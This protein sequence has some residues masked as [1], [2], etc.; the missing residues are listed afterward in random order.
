M[1]HTPPISPNFINAERD[2]HA[3]PSVDV[4]SNALVRRKGGGGHGGGH[5]SG[6]HSGGGGRGSSSGHGSSG[7]HGSSSSGSSRP[8]KPKIPS[9]FSRSP[10]ALPF[11]AGAAIGAAGTRAIAYSNGGGKQFTLG[12]SSAFPGRAAGGGTRL[13]IFGTRRYGSGYPYGGT[14][15]G[16]RGRPFPFLFFPIVISSDANYYNSQEIISLNNTLRPGGP[17]SQAIIYTDN[18][19]NLTGAAAANT[20]TYRI[21]GDASS[22]SVAYTALIVSCSLP[23]TTTTTGQQSLF[24]PSSNASIPPQPSQVVQYYRA[25]SFALTLDTYANPA[26]AIVNSTAPDAALP[27]NLNLTLL[28]CINNT[29]GASLPLLVA[30]Q[31]K[32]SHNEVAG[33][34]IGSVFLVITVLALWLVCSRRRARKAREVGKENREAAIGADVHRMREA[35]KNAAERGAYVRVEHEDSDDG[36]GE[37]DGAAPPPHMPE[38]HLFI[39]EPHVQGVR[40]GVHH[41][42]KDHGHLKSPFET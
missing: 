1:P 33:I 42:E 40:D 17:L 30:P 26:G 13:G 16:I 38:P 24:T 18:T 35:E 29:I 7:G 32:L 34:V 39:P 9:A 22:V 36:E 25:S 27:A 5:S 19:S 20:T 11:A 41:E 31:S 4:D 28:A 23:N 15:Y 2:L 3:D 12:P 14:G 8:K 6:G 21:I 37:V 10:A